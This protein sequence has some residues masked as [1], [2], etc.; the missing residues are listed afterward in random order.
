MEFEPKRA[1]FKQLRPGPEKIAD[2]IRAADCFVAIA[3]RRTKVEDPGSWI[4]PEW[5]QSEIGM[6]YRA[7]KPMAIFVEEGIDYSGLGPWATDIVSFGRTD[8]GVTS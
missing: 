6:P 8:F 5:V 7:S 3:A 4:G 2:M 1:D